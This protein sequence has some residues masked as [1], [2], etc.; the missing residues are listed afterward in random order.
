MTYK[1]ATTGVKYTKMARNTY[2]YIEGTMFF[3]MI[4]DHKDKFDRYSLTLGIEGDM[5]KSAK[6]MGMTVKQD[7]ERYDGMAY[8]TL[9]SNHAPQLFDGDGQEYSGARMLSNGSKGVCKITQ[10]P[11][12]NKYGKGMTTFLNAV[13]ITDPIEY[14]PDGSK[15]NS[16][17][18]EESSEEVPF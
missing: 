8:V 3:P 7:D 9:K 6:K 15:S 10:R 11:Y 18:D 14:I 5:V 12:D 1:L 13:K 4:F 17:G 16:F 2:T